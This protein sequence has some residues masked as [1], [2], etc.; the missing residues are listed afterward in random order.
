MVCPYCG[1]NAELVDSI[2]VYR[3]SYGMIWLCQP[4]QAWVGTHKDSKT[5]KPLGTLARAELRELRQEAHAR[6]DPFWRKLSE[7]G[8][9][10]GTARKTLYSRLAGLMGI[11]SSA[12]HIA[13]FGEEQCRQVIE[14]CSGWERAAA[15]AAA[16]D[17]RKS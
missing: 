10:K 4:C 12:C 5:H 14:I 15:E 2:A 1:F 17:S 6:F 3:K 13:Q 8:L 9:S 11:D 7:R 16:L